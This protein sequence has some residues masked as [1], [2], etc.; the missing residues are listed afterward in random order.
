MSILKPFIFRG[1]SK[2]V[3]LL[4]ELVAELDNFYNP[5]AISR[6]IFLCCSNRCLALFLAMLLSNYLRLL[7]NIISGDP[8]HILFIKFLQLLLPHVELKVVKGFALLLA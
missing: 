7:T 6:I 1:V 4:G 8:S 3:S 5:E 2:E